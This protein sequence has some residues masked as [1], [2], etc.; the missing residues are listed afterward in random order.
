VP[1]T[2]KSALIEVGTELSMAE[3]ARQVGNTTRS[4]V[5]A[6]GESRINYWAAYAT[7]FSCP[8]IL[9]YLGM[10][11]ATSWPAIVFS[12]LL[13]LFF[14]SLIEYVVHRW[15]LHD[16][17]SPLYYLHDA[18]HSNP[19]KTSA[20]LFPTGL[21]VFM[22]AWCLLTWGLHIQLAAYFLMGVSAGN[23]YF[24]TL[25][26][27]EHTTR[28]NHIPFRWLQKK[29]AFHSVHHRLDHSNFGV[30]TPFWDHVFGT[31]QKQIKRRRS[32][33]SAL[34]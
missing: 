7:D 21:V 22:S 31:H 3:R 30:I 26:H 24:D 27:V 13:G 25:H 6:I 23:F 8:C 15:L 11:H 34:R 33:A 12:S 17:R 16:L 32:R 4:M 5:E 18:H 1:G 28:V 19:G 2:R 20:F 10:Q 9:A 14:F 29:W